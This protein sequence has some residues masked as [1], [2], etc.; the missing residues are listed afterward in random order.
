[1][2]KLLL[3]TLLSL[4]AVLAISAAACLGHGGVV[5]APEFRQNQI[6][7][8]RCGD[9]ISA[10]V[11]QAPQPEEALFQ[12]GVLGDPVAALS[13]SG[14]AP[15]PLSAR[16]V[17]SCFELARIL[18]LSAPSQR[19]FLPAPDAAPRIHLWLASHLEVRAGPAVA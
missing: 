1:V 19:V 6:G 8:D 18:A 16:L 17:L 7:S 5:P 2:K 10:V 11:P 4:S 12:T 3:F 13:R 14:G 15:R 9:A